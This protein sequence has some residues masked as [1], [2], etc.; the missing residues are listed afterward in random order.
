MFIFHIALSLAMIT[1][2]IGLV[3]LVW[4]KKEAA[5]SCLLKAGGIIMLVVSLLNI[6][7]IGYYGIRYGQDGYFRAPNVMTHDA[8]SKKMMKDRGGKMD[9]DHSMMKDMMKK[10]ENNEMKN[11]MSDDQLAAPNTD[12][13][14]TSD[15]VQPDNHEAHHPESTGS[16]K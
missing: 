15:Q 9:M 6:V 3:L 1:A 11:K 2:A 7:C 5:G 13:D 12:Q 4:S 14:Q 8:M 10:G 16:A